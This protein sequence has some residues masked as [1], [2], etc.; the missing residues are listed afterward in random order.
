MLKHSLKHLFVLFRQQLLKFRLLFVSTIDFNNHSTILI[1]APHP[2]DE[3]FGCG[4]FLPEYLSRGGVAYVVYLTDGE[5]SLSDLQ[6]VVVGRERIKINERV[7]DMLDIRNDRRYYLNLADGKLPR[8]GEN[9]FIEVVDSLKRLLKDIKPDAVF[10]TDKNE[11]WP[12]DHVAAFEMADEAIKDS[13]IGTSLYSYWVWVWYSMPIKKFRGIDWRHTYRIPIHAGIQKK[14]EF[15]NAYLQPL[16]PDGRP[17]CGV[18][19]DALLKA[20]DYP[21]EI[22]TKITAGRD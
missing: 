20:F 22:V 9:G 18:L 13:D 5:N 19:P 12:F 3:I 16:A 4:G 14:K 8:K 15:I 7:L 21:Y 11:T 10:V 1:I 6:P 2:D 17:W